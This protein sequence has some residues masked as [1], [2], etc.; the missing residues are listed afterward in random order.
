MGII[1]VVSILYSNVIGSK[2]GDSIT[3]YWF[4]SLFLVGRDTWRGRAK[5]CVLSCVIKL[6]C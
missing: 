1:I 3:R 5:L 4:W 6:E 2:W